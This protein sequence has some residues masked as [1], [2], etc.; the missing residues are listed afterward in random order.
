MAGRILRPAAV[1][2]HK[3][4]PWD[5]CSRA[6]SDGSRA[7]TDAG[8]AGR[9]LGVERDFFAAREGEKLMAPEGSA[10]HPLFGGIRY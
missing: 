9:D 1:S 8:S 7:G 10:Y 5:G 2:G 4:R 3:E 6:A